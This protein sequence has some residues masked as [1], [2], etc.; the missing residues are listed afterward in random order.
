MRRLGGEKHSPCR[1]L[2]KEERKPK[3][4]R[5]PDTAKNLEC[6]TEGLRPS[7]GKQ[8]AIEGGL[9]SAVIALSRATDPFYRRINCSLGIREVHRAAPGHT[10]GKEQRID[11]TPGLMAPKPSLILRAAAASEDLFPKCLHPSD[12]NAPLQ[13]WLCGSWWCGCSDRTPRAH[14]CSVCLCLLSLTPWAHLPTTP[15]ISGS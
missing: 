3:R 15:G 8:G 11:S 1:Q 7:Q 5:I 10:A 4:K 2:P 6:P 14:L 13:L 9:D 12:I